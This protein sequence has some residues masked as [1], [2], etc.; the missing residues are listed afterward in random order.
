MKPQDFTRI[1][2]HFTNNGLTVASARF[3]FSKFIE[4]VGSAMEEFEIKESRDPT[5]DEIR[6]ICDNNLSSPILETYLE[7][8]K[9]NQEAEGKNIAGKYARDGGIGWWGK[10]VAVTMFANFL[11][12]TF[13]LL[14][15]KFGKDQWDVILNELDTIEQSEGVHPSPPVGTVT[16]PDAQ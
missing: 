15:F 16:D 4:S 9:I 7:L 10:S 1:E 11:F 6:Q 2:N 13:L 12:L 14:S 8:A 3:A 5:E